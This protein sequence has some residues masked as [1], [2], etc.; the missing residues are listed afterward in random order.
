LDK[1]DLLQDSEVMF[2]RLVVKA[3]RAPEF[4]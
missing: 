3:D 2:D 4:R 1:T